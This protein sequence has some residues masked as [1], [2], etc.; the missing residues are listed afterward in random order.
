MS[1]VRFHCPSASLS[2]KG[3]LKRTRRALWIESVLA[4]GIHLMFTQ[5]GGFG[6]EQKVAKPLTTQFIKRQPRLTKPLEMKKR[7]QPKRRRMQ[8]TMVSVKAKVNRQDVTSQIQ[9]LQVMRSLAKPKTHVGRSL[10]A[11]GIGMEPKAIAEEVAG[12]MNPKHIVDMSLEMVDI[13]ALDTGRYQA[14]VIQDPNDKRRISGYFHFWMAWGL[15]YSKT[16]YNDWPNR[17]KYAIRRMV[18]K[19]NEWTDIKTDVLGIVGFDSEEI[20]KTPWIV[21]AFQ[22][23]M[24]PTDPEL[25]NMG[26]YMTT[27]GFIYTHGDPERSGRAKVIQQALASVGVE[28]CKDWYWERLPH[29]HSLFHCYF[30]FPNGP[31]TGARAVGHVLWGARIPEPP[32]I[33]AILLGERL[34]VITNNAAYLSPWG[35]WGKDGM[36]SMRNS[37]YSKYDPRRQLEFGINTIIFALTQEGSI[38]HRLMDSVR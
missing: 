37:V 29:S 35:D 16:W 4:L 28:K 36:P 1:S 23:K 24:F 7:P 17:Y 20:L 10:T 38:T 30:D 8:R 3:L 12:S 34:A 11:G 33:D 27:G 21:L 14:M 5:L 15:Y 6:G 18:L 13:E 26:R 22:Y 2:L 31:P 32:R 19:M 25:K 9:A